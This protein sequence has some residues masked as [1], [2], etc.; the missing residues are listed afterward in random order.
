MRIGIHPALKRHDGGIY[1]YTTALL[2]ALHS[3]STGP[4]ARFDHEFVVFVHDQSDPI[5]SELVGERWRVESFRPP[6]AP[7]PTNE[8]IFPED[9]DLPLEQADMRAWLDEC[10]IELMIYPSPH[11]LSFEAGVPFVMAIHDLQHLLQPEF[12][13]VS[14]HGEWRRREYVLRNA[15]RA[16]TLL[17]AESNIG[18]EDILNAYGSCGVRPNDVKTLPYLPQP[19]L[20]LMEARERL[21]AN[22]ERFDLPER[23]FFYPAQFWPHKNHLRLVEALGI[24]KKRQGLEIPLVLTGSGTGEIREHVVANMRSRRDQL[25][26]AGQVRS[27][28]YVDDEDIAVLYSGAVALVMPTFFGPTNIP[29]LEA[30][31]FDCPVLTSRIR[32]IV[33]QV[34]DAAVTIDPTQAEDIANGI[35]RLWTDEQLRRDLIENGR[36]KL[37]LYTPSDYRQR[38]A[39]IVDEA[40]QR[41]QQGRRIAAGALAGGSCES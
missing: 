30:W 25:G 19:R 41:V 7:M 14:A 8:L 39:G 15:A 20:S 40:V 22:R 31:S 1:Q 13:E 2:R 36:R 17:I 12:P 4:N 16:A 35:R 18:R 27:L 5:L 28:G 26:V 23:Y 32:G 10:G 21:P 38:L 29:F 24:L 9:V 34:G 3:L 11:R 37:A 33:E 6:W